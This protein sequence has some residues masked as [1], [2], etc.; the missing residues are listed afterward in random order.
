[1]SSKIRNVRISIGAFSSRSQKPK[2]SVDGK[3]KK[4]PIIIVN[5]MGLIKMANIVFGEML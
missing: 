4:D 1:M 3:T 5:G 2:L